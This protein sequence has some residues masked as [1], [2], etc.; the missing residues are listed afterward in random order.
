MLPSDPRKLGVFGL[1]KSCAEQTPDAPAIVGLRDGALTYGKLQSHVEGVVAQ[2]NALGVGRN[3]RVAVVL[4]NGP[5]MAVAFVA[6]AAAATCA[7]LNPAYR[8]KEFDFYLSDLKAR[9]LIALAGQ[10][11]PAR[12]VAHARGIPVLDLVPATGESAG[13]FTLRGG[14]VGPPPAHPGFAQ[15]DDVALVLHTSGTTARPKIVPLTHAN[16][17]S[18]AL[19]IKTSLRLTA[20]DGC[21]NIMPLFHIHGLIG[22]TLPSLAAGARIVCTPGLDAPRFLGW[23][24]AF[25][26]TWYTAVPTMHQAILAQVSDNQSVLS[27]CPLRF[28]RSCSAP[29]PPQLMADLEGVFQAP[30]IEAY[31]MTEASHQMAT[32]P[33]PAARRKPGS[34]G[35]ASGADIAI[36][37]DAGRLLAAGQSGEVVIRGPGVTHGYENN[38]EANRN[39]FTG[40]WFRTGDRGRLDEEGYLFLT[41]R[42]KELINRGG[43][44]ISPRE[45]DEILLEHPAV[46]QALA[47]A[48]PHPT[49]GEDVAAAVVLRARASPADPNVSPTEK[50]LREFAAA[51]LADFKVPRRVLLVSELPKGPTGKP[52][53][54]GLADKLG[55]TARGAGAEEKSGFTAPRSP[56]EEVL[57]AIWAE[58]L[59]LPKI[60]VHD[61]FFQCGGNSLLAATMVARLQ[62]KMGRFL[63]V[64]AMIQ[65]ATIEHVARLLDQQLASGS[66][67][68]ALQPEGAQPPFYCVH[69]IGGEALDLAE[70]ARHMAPDYP[71]HGLQIQRSDDGAPVLRSIEQMAARY[72][73]E[74]CAFQPQ[75]PYFLGGVSFGGSVAFEMAQQLQAR[76]R[77]VGLLAI[78]DH[79]APGRTSQP[80]FWTPSFAVRFLTNCCSWIRY[81]LLDRKRI[82]VWR[83]A[84]LK[85]RVGM[86]RIGNVF[87][88]RPS[89]SAADLVESIFDTSRLPD[90]FRKT[91]EVH[92]QA[93]LNYKPTGYPGRITL[94]RASAQPLLRAPRYDLGWSKLAAGGVDVSVIPGS[95][96]TIFIDPY[97]QLLAEQLK[98]HI[99]KAQTVEGA[100]P[101]HTGPGVAV[102]SQ[103]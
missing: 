94:I 31:G 63:P 50:D 99:R 103:F 61:D 11:S 39:S 52:Q 92:Y 54:I 24:E 32:N 64:A 90:V 29:L 1:L 15:A 9:A 82:G 41:G 46:A 66:S 51:R 56:T 88:R 69:G 80:S 48:M 85:M 33:L 89:G 102:S 26:P 55:L 4:P 97:L 5:A 58:L 53:R 16:L 100:L 84:G 34:V 8:D 81:D 22:A 44:K 57:A 37:D 13:L 18:S 10:D 14:E 40:G 72:V 17:C 2:L 59:R 49:L 75:G 43:E 21:L 87:R 35:I 60:G 67:L 30:V 23:L 95:H 19:S 78:L 101:V 76:G 62:K 74:I 68:I 36:M 70:L 73:D 93:L 77:Q 7:P 96:Y 25:R 20:Q 38:P 91:L 6:V 71:F 83:R 65:G 47:F 86:K 42:I 3:D 79:I 27:R 12:G 98:A 45:V 28:L